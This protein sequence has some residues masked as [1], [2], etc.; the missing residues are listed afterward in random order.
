MVQVFETGSLPERKLMYLALEHT[1]D[2]M[3]IERHN[4]PEQNSILEELIETKQKII[5]IADNQKKAAGD[6]RFL[7]IKKK[8]KT[9]LEALSDLQPE[10]KVLVEELVQKNIKEFWSYSNRKKEIEN[11]NES[12]AVMSSANGK[13]VLKNEQYFVEKSELF[14]L[15]IIYFSTFFVEKY[16][17]I[18]DFS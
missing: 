9:I 15:L 13:E 8:G 4:Q 14:L 5:Q 10:T 12:F 7:M 6:W 16:I 1:M 3:I 2:S 17:I 11:I 18:V